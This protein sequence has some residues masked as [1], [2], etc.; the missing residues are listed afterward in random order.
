MNTED[1]RFNGTKY[2]TPELA[3]RARREAEASEKRAQDAAARRT[4]DFERR[5]RDRYLAGGGT[6]ATWELEKADVL[7]EARKQAAIAGDDAARR[8]SAGRYR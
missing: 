2:P 4:A 6:S 5:V 1:L 8:A 7:R 3:Q